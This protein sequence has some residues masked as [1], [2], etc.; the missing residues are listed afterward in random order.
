MPKEIER[1]F[2]VKSEPDEQIV[3]NRNHVSQGYL[4]IGIDYEVRIS[5]KLHLTT[6]SGF[7]LTR[8]ENI[9]DITPEV[10]EALLPLTAGKRIDKIRAVCQLD[11]GLKAEFDSYLGANEGLRTVE[12][13]FES[14]EQANSFVPPDWFGEDVTHISTYKNS[15][16]AK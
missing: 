7:G 15:L 13:E 14:E 5:N 16:L 6:K 1:K 4:K 8:E 2:L 10:Y 3:L 11:N 12:V 9:Y